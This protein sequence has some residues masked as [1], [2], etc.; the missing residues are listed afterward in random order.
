MIVASQLKVHEV[1][2][3][4]GGI[5]EEYATVSDHRKRVCKVPSNLKYVEVHPQP[6]HI[7]IVAVSVS[8]GT[9]ILIKQ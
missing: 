1:G 8:F 6:A 7:V 5:R 4:E 2:V 3:H 9:L